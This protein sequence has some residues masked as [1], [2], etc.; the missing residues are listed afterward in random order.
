M[1]KLINQSRLQKF[2]EG[3]WTKI[4]DRY[5]DAF[6]GA[7]LTA[8]E[9]KIKFTKKKGG[10]TVDVDLA[11]Y[12]RLQDRNEFKQDVS[13]DNVAI[14]DNRNIGTDFGADSKDRSLGFR[15][16]TTDSFSFKN[17]AC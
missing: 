10:P 1:S 4:K 8:A 11:D 9:K 2:A 13:A 16:L 12:A 14:I 7:T 15:R 5:D 17:N 3:L 6:V